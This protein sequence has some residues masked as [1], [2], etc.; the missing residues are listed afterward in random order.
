MN[1]TTAYSTETDVESAVQEIK[2]KLESKGLKAVL[3]FA[4]SSYDPALLSEKMQAA[5]GNVLTFGCSTSG[6]IVTG[7]MLENSVVA[8]SFSNETLE[9]VK[10]IVLKNIS[11][12]NPVDKGFEVFENYFGES[13]IQMD[14]KKYVGLILID[15]LSGAEEKLMERIGDL[16]NV[17]FIGASAG[18]DLKF[19]ETYV[20]ANGKSHTDSALLILLKPKVE[21][22]FIKTQ[23]F[24]ELDK[25][26]VATSVDEP[27]RIVHEFNGK[28]AVQAYAEAIGVDVENVGNEF[29][30]HPVGLMLDDEP[31]VRS[32]QQTQDDTIV[33]YCNVKEG[34]ELSVLESTDII[35][36]TRDVL[37]Q[38][39]DELGSASGIINF[40]C[41]LRTLELKDKNLMDEYGE[42]FTDVP[43]IGFSTYGEEFVGHIN[44][45]STMLVFK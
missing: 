20:Y 40:H 35:K 44:Q 31:Y 22:D 26:L 18:D 6:E 4:S 27:K 2:S 30:R 3:Y 29:M 33:F 5:F 14:A 12:T 37:N 36:D 21:F 34:M 16:T 11:T 19:K 25:H 7:K 41:I 10:A 17:V 42:I 13:M 8:M 38:K 1:I 45:T 28:P 39:L 15:G 43:T 32:P 23:S 9:D 24:V